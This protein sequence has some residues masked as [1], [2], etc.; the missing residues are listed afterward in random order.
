[1]LRLL[2]EIDI[3]RLVEIEKISQSSPWS[4]D[5]FC[6]CFISGCNFW[7][8]ELENKIVG[9]IIVSFDVLT[10]GHILNFSVDPGWQKKGI[11]CLLLKT[12]LQYAKDN[13]ILRLWLEVRRSN[14]RAI[15]IYR[16]AGFD[17]VGERK[18][19]Y[20]DFNDREDA[21]IFLIEL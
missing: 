2:S 21:L 6:N 20:V 8:V 16:Q 9:F 5:I 15:L 4:E 14:E 11:G 19:Y 12:V 13:Q 18:N 17:C 7:G 1:L 10:E 3:P